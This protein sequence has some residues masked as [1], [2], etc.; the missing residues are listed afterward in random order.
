MRICT[1]SIKRAA[2]KYSHRRAKNTSL[3]NSRPKTF[4]IKLE[5]CAR[6][7]LGTYRNVNFFTN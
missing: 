2:K 5:E 4:V 7:G 1:R 3:P 6:S